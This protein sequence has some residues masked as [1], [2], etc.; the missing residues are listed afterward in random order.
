MLDAATQ[1]FVARG[2]EFT[3]AD[4]AA[5]AGVSEGTIFRY[6]PDKAALV[7]AAKGAAL[8]LN[9]LAPLLRSAAA[10]PTLAQ[11]LVAAAHAI[12]PRI[13][14]MA[15][16][17]DHAHQLDRRTTPDDHLVRDLL[18]QLTPLFDDSCGTFATSDQLA[19]LFLGSLLA[20]TVLGGK[21]GVTPLD[22]DRL[23]DVFLHGIAGR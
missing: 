12:A 10:L 1:L 21:G 5:A 2:Y 14:Q 6:F 20:N 7:D 8:D 4:L 18:E 16:V 22:V 23:A 13:E 19:S 3:T 15:R 9:G 11:R 17:V